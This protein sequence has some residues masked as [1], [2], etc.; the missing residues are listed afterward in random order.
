[1]TG[2]RRV[3]LA[4]WPA[5]IYMAL[6]WALSSLSTLPSIEQVPFQD[7]GAHFIEYGVLGFLYSYALTR[8]FPQWKGL[9]VFLVTCLLASVWGGLDELHQA[10]VPGRSSTLSD[11][12]A[13]ALGALLAA[14]LYQ[15]V[16]SVAL[17]RSTRRA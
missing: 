15:L 9:R 7:K 17:R 13:D 4:W 12:C 1:L 6:I 5:I 11:V 16:A 3:L 14:S 2:Y 10:F 8:Y